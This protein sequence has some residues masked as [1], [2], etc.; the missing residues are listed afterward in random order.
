[1]YTRKELTAV[2]K[3]AYQ[4]AES[5]GWHEVDRTPYELVMLMNSEL[6]EATEELRQHDPMDIYIIDGKPEGFLIEI[7]D[8]IIRLFDTVGYF[9]GDER[10]IYRALCDG[11]TS[12]IS[13]IWDEKL[14]S[15]EVDPAQLICTF[16]KLLFEAVDGIV[17][18]NYSKAI[19]LFGSICGIADEWFDSHGQSLK[20][21][22]EQK[23]EYNST[24][25]HR[26][27]GKNL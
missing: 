15:K 27:G 17:V 11:H 8:F 5:K 1:M 21:V 3:K 25:S 9:E 13:Y 22:I 2:A 20:K 19:H 23:M 26:H 4:N 12:A 16:G 7:A 24:R 14:K 18:G 6:G 10:G